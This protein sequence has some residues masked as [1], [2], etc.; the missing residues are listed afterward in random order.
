MNTAFRTKVRTFPFRSLRCCFSTLR[1][2]SSLVRS[3]ASSLDATTPP[4]D[5][6]TLQHAGITECG[7]YID[8]TFHDQSAYRFH[9]AWLNDSASERIGPE[10][11]RQSVT[12]VWDLPTTFARD[13]SI[14][15]DDSMVVTLDDG[16]A[17]T[18]HAIWMRAWA[19]FVAQPLNERS[20]RLHMTGGTASM[21][22]PCMAHRTPWTAAALEVVPTFD[23]Q[24]LLSGMD[25]DYTVR[26]LE[27]MVDPGL[28]MIENM[29]P[30][31]SMERSQV[32]KTLDE[33]IFEIVGKMN[34]HPI[35]EQRY[36]VIQK[37]KAAKIAN[38]GKDYNHSDPLSMHTDHSPYHGIPGFLQFMYQAEGNVTSKVCDGLAVA[39]Y[40]QDHHPQAFDILCNVE[41]THAIRNMVYT[42]DGASRDLNDPH[43]T[44]WEFELVHTHPILQMKDGVIERIVQS[45]SKRGICSFGFDQFEQVLE[46]Y[47]LWTKLC[48]DERFVKS[49]HWPEHTALVTNNWRVLHGRASVAPD[50]E[51]TMVFGYANKNLVDNR[52]RLLKMKQFARDKNISEKFLMRNPNQVLMYMLAN[53]S[54]P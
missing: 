48:E 32:G 54:A 5:S 6:M 14:S 16:T 52:Y 20:E 53:P 2:S 46:A 50:V 39:Q 33:L 25:I 43:A 38:Q 19:P 41:F 12:A 44:P 10:T 15:A 30:P 40:V 3:T 9:S 1:R 4:D 28:A 42:K 34:A 11:H 35:R 31:A 22:D 36:G 45:E 47:N 23:A 37:K 51:R 24:R 26:F 7:K 21:L 17:I 13:L 27:H 29:G 18:L 8:V 49:F